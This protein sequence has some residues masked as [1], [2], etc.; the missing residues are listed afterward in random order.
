MTKNTR[1]L[2]TTVALAL[3]IPAAQ[4]QL[5]IY[6]KLD[7]PHYSDNSSDSS[8]ASG[9][10]HGG[11]VGIYDDFFHL[12]PVH[13]GADLRGDFATH[14]TYR[15]RS[16]AGGVRIAAKLPAIP[17]RPYVEGLAGVG[18]TQYTG[19]LAAGI[20]SSPY[21]NKFT[22]QVLGGLDLTIFP[23]LDFRT[24]EIGVGRQSGV[25]SGSSTP[26]ATLVLLSTG[27]VLRL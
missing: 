8:A 26:A 12:G 18:G 1:L 2:L 25:G 23:H 10:Y 7:L 16:I 3:G 5:G 22:Y 6:G 4:A 21:S 14:D 19:A 15:L 27:L 11:G 20:S 24:I 13:L 17:L 9:W